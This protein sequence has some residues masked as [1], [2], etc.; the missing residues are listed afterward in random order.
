MCADIDKHR[1]AGAHGRDC[2]AQGRFS[3]GIY[4]YAKS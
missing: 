2:E 3:A 1:D 4:T